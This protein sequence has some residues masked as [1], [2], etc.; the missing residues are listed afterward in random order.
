[1]ARTLL[2]ISHSTE[3]SKLADAWKKLVCSVF[4]N[5]GDGAVFFSS[6]RCAFHGRA[7]WWSQLMQKIEESPILISLQ[8]P[9]SSKRP[10]VVFEAGMAV[11]IK[12]TALYPVIF[13][14]RD[15]PPSKSIF[16]EKLDNPMTS[17]QQYRGTSREDVTAIL[18]QLQDEFQKLPDDPKPLLNATKLEE[19]L[20][21]YEKSILTQERCWRRDR[22]IFEKRIRLVFNTAQIEQLQASSE[23]SDDVTLE[24][25]GD[26]LMIFDE[27]KVTV[28]WGEFI[29]HLESM[30]LPWPGSAARWARGLGSTLRKALGD[31]LISD[32]EGLPLYFD[33][34]PSQ[35]KSYR[36]SVVLREEYGC[37][38]YFVISFTLLPPELRIR[39]DGRPG[40]L[41][42]YLD[43]CRMM[44]WGVLEDK[45]FVNF[46]IAPGTFTETDGTAAI[47]AFIERILTI[48]TEFWNRGLKSDSLEGVIS[49]DEANKVRD[50][51]KRYMDAIQIIDPDNKG[52]APQKLP[53]I[54]TLQELYSNLLSINKEYY[55]IVHDAFAG[56]VEKL[57]GSL[58]DIR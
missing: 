50:L 33:A 18:M 56:E 37:K 8:T 27:P 44:R 38:T 21:E 26:A 11:A 58:Q 51:V 53:S 28:K 13:E 29:Q 34:R 47:E 31:K 55:A 40:V 42:H 22:T 23:I 36:P 49:S 10:W 20:D 43:F 3:E 54:A 30:Q 17:I 9:V 45:M 15:I 46:F 5:L 39:P 1:M 25:V 41:L 4:R 7:P 6:E 48:R 14:P 57:S 32:P 52:V 2:I 24:S 35:F 16:G 12:G 19:S